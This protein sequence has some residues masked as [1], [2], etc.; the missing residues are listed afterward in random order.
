VFHLCVVL[1]P[2]LYQLLKP[3]QMR[4]QTLLLLAILLL[5]L[6]AYSSP[7]DDYYSTKNGKYVGNDGIKSKVCRLIDRDTF[8]RIKAQFGKIKNDSL[9]DLL[10][11]A[12]LLITVDTPEIRMDLLQ[13]RDNSIRDSVEHQMYIFLDKTSG[14]ISSHMGLHGD[15]NNTTI[16]C[17]Y[18]RYDSVDYVDTDTGLINVHILIGQAH[19]HPS[20]TNPKAN[21][22]NKMS[23][24]DKRVAKELQAAIYGIGATGDV[25]GEIGNI[26]RANPGS[27]RTT[28]HVGKILGS[29]INEWN[30]DIALDALKIWGHSKSP[31][32]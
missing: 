14:V 27:R 23:K 12:S 4:T 13:V 1:T 22:T 15:N 9:I 16:V 24:K 6:N 10:H 8:N 3:A 25:K 20:S 18:S 21:G 28:Y 7:W 26:N 2:F 32:P 11:A 19:G 31:K 30:V 5:V 29:D 17:Q